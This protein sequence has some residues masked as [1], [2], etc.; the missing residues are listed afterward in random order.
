MQKLLSYICPALYLHRPA[1]NL[2]PRKQLSCHFCAAGVPDNHKPWS[3]NRRRHGHGP[4]R[5]G[6]H[7][8][9]G[10]CA[11]PPNS[12]LRASADGAPPRRARLPDLRGCAWRG[13]PPVQSFRPQVGST[14][15]LRHRLVADMCMVCVGLSNFS[16]QA[17][18]YLT[19]HDL[20]CTSI[21]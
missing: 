18:V 13:W 21:A 8:Q 14:C 1:P 12:L 3:C 16:L 5:P 4:P 6:G 10:V 20:S 17:P 11:V 2:S 19:R 9:H 15:P 7:G